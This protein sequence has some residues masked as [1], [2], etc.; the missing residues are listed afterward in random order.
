MSKKDLYRLVWAKYHGGASRKL[1]LLLIA[2]LSKTRTAA[3]SIKF[4]AKRCG[5][6]E[7]QSQYIVNEMLESGLLV[8]LFNKAGG[9]PGA[10]RGIV[11]NEQAL[12]GE[13]GC[14]PTGEVFSTRQATKTGEASCTQE[15]SK[16]RQKKPLAKKAK[17][18]PVLRLVV[19]GE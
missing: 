8:C 3:P 7:R 16:H 12:T 15:V 6:S 4:I 19:G 9:K 13:A 1:V 14:T 2:D 10:T 18:A 17:I 5:I 11:I